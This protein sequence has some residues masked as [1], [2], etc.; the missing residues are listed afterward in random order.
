MNRIIRSRNELHCWAD[1][2]GNQLG[3][4]FKAHK[5]T[6]QPYVPY[7][8]DDQNAK[9][10]AMMGELAKFTGHS[11]S[12]IKDYIKVE[13]APSKKVTIGKYTN[14]VPVSSTLWDVETCSMIIEELYRI[15][16]EIGYQFQETSEMIVQP[17][18]FK[19]QVTVTP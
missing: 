6:I 8:T 10:H 17:T 12:D 19:F 5:V 14:Q 11:A 1:D 16:A 13:F 9:V 15:G 4:N 18:D 2:V 3:E 7:R